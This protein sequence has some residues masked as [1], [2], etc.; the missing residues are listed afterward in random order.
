MFSALAGGLASAS[1]YLSVALVFAFLIPLQMAFGRLGRRGGIYAAGMSA[2]GIAL[3]QSW[4]LIAGGVTELSLGTLA[5]ILYPLLLVG[6]LVVL[7]ASP[8]RILAPAIRILIAS[9]AL[10]LCMLP[11]V[12]QLLGDLPLRQALTSALSSL[13]DG[14]GKSLADGAM[15][16]GYDGAALKASLDPAELVD[17]TLSMFASC[18]AGLIF[19]V[20]GGS[21]WI[22]NRLSGEGSGGRREAPSLRD[23]RLPDFIVWPFLACLGFLL[24]TMALRADS[25]TR[26]AA[27][28]LALVFALAY[29]A[30]GTG[31][32]AH[33]LA[34]WKVPRFFRF[35][36][37]LLVALSAASSPVGAGLLALLPVLG[38]T[39]LWIPYRN[40]KGVGA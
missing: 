2:L 37:V 12:V 33:Y 39:E 28:N 18:Y 21:W 11:L 16:G 7:N 15:V 36:M 34:H 9:F 22:G 1:F 20:L 13:V 40:P 38:V 3:V 32:V 10:A 5:G 27:W 25:A 14:F 29:A 19:I 30:Q 4:R 8:M 17:S 31:I 26:A 6:A 24:A 23:F 35:V